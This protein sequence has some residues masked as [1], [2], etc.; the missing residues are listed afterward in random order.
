M[1]PQE[2]KEYDEWTNANIAFVRREYADSIM[3]CDGGF[4]YENADNPPARFVF[5]TWEEAA[6]DLAIEIDVTD[7]ERASVA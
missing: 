5:P 1:T 6:A 2:A 3:P 7:A 4:Y